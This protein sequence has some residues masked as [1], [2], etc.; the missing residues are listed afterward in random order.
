MMKPRPAIIRVANEAL[1]TSKA[2]RTF[3][4]QNGF[5]SHSVSGGTFADLPVSSKESLM[6]RFKASELLL[7]GSKGAVAYASSGSSGTPSL[8]FRDERTL[9][10][11]AELHETVFRHVFD[12]PPKESTLVVVTF[13]MGMWVAGLFTAEAC[14]MLR[15]RGLEVTIATPGIDRSEALSA[16]RTAAPLFKHVVIA[17]YPPTVLDLLR[18]AKR[19]R[20]MHRSMYVLTA[21]DR[22]TET[23][24]DEIAKLIGHGKSLNRVISIYGAADAASIA[25]ETP[26]TISLKRR[27]L[28]DKKLAEILF[29]DSRAHGGLYQYLPDMLHLEAYQGELLITKRMPLPLVRYNIH[30]R[31]GVWMPAEFG[32]KGRWKTLPLV[33]VNGRTDVALT[34]YALNIYPEQITAA[35]PHGTGAFAAY[36]HPRRGGHSEELVIE[37]EKGG[38]RGTQKLCDAVVRGLLRTNTEY[39]KLH[40]SIGAAALPRILLVP[41][42]SLLKKKRGT[43]TL[44]GVPGKKP[45]VLPA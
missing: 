42:G 30:D 14:E 16:L 15:G 29:G 23:F 37:V 39:K 18:D 19:E 44:L 38:G 40:A 10:E 36:A 32:C 21:G 27:A 33:S 2:Y 45:R 28:S 1:K 31:G 17:G 3:A 43:R 41:P 34:F 22:S 24:R 6:R 9:L 25:F 8:W 13:S 5:P 11:G 7:S 20:V 4:K 26:Y 12:I 35:I